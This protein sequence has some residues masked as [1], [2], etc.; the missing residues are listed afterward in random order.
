MEL[1]YGLPVLVLVCC[2][3]STGEKI[4]NVHDCMIF[5]YTKFIHQV[6]QIQLRECIQGKN[7]ENLA[8]HRYLN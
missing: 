5:H 2:V 1:M 3:A 6:C 7:W 4:R 8:A